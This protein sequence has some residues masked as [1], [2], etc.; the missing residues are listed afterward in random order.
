[1]RSM[2]AGDV[3]NSCI[4]RFHEH[5]GTHLDAPR[6]FNASGP[7]IAEMPFDR[8]FYEAPLLLDIPKGSCERLEP[9]D[10]QPFASRIAGADFLM[11]RTGFGAYRASDPRKYQMESPAISARGCE[12]LVRTFGGRLK[13]VCLDVQ[14]L[15]NASDT[16]GDGIEAHRWMLGAYTP[17]YICVIEDANLAVI[18][19][20]ARIVRAASV[21]LR[22]LGTDSGPVT[23][24]VELA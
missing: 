3:N 18:P 2:A 6:H 15:G 1:M 20:D 19:A 10:F 24:W 12:Y 8:F 23:A 5:Y 13:T 21:P 14:S 16:S 7:T 9:E 11:V 22:T 4:L 17:D